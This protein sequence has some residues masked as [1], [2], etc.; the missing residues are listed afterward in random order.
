MQEAPVVYMNGNELNVEN[1]NAAEVTVYN[2]AGVKVF[3]DNSGEA[4]VRTQLDMRGAYI[5]KV[6]NA[7]VKV[8]R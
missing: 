6:G 4:V 1:P 5:V 7:V 3:S 2:M 8:M